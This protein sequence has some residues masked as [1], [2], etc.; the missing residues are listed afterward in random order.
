MYDIGLFN[1]FYVS[2]NLN[3]VNYFESPHKI[4]LG[5]NRKNCTKSGVQTTCISSLLYFEEVGK[6]FA[7]LLLILLRPRAY[8]T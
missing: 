3:G 8:F 7:E 6:S 2:L 4:S 5:G 1:G